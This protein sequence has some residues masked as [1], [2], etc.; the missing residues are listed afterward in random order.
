MRFVEVDMGVA[1]GG[2]GDAGCEGEDAGIG[3]GESR[4][5]CGWGLWGSRGCY[6]GYSAGCGGNVDVVV[7]GRGKMGKED[8]AEEGEGLRRVKRQGGWWRGGGRWRGSGAG[9]LDAGH[10]GLKVDTVGGK[11]CSGH[12]EGRAV[13]GGEGWGG[14]Y[15][16]RVRVG[17]ACGHDV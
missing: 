10:F 6:G 11:E 4:W 14:R 17:L 7:F 1:E 9:K 16:V 2:E 13:L 12:N 15:R 5:G 8:A 3:G